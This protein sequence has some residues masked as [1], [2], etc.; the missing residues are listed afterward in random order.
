MNTIQNQ[1][2][3]VLVVGSGITGLMTAYN[4]ALAGYAVRV[5]SKSPDSRLAPVGTRFESS[6]WD[7]YVN[8]YITLTEGNPYLDLPGYITTMYPGIDTDFRQDL[9]SGFHGG[10]DYEHD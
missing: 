7:G 10:G 1:Q 2:T 9:C 4:A 6:I 8:R 3:P 5:I